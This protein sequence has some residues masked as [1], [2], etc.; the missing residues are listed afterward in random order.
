M[1]GKRKEVPADGRELGVDDKDDKD[2]EERGVK[3]GSN[4]GQQRPTKRENVCQ[5][6]EP[7]ST[8]IETPTGMYTTIMT[9]PKLDPQTTLFFLC[10]VQT[11]FS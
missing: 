1:G 6:L 11:K 7:P 10:D 9:T 3:N 5:D 8:W 2:R 4:S